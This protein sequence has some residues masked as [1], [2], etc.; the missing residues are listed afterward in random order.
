MPDNQEG[1]HLGAAGGAESANG[2]V[3]LVDIENATVCFG[4]MRGTRPGTVNSASQLAQIRLTSLASH[5]ALR[6]RAVGRMPVG[7]YKR[8]EGSGRNQGDGKGRLGY[9]PDAWRPPA[10][11]APRPSRSR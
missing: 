11:P 9:G 3:L 5:R 2:R 7:R 10:I 1:I 8:N 6:S 4:R